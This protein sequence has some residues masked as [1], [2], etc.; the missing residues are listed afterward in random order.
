MDKINIRNLE[1][2]AN[3]GVFPEENV[4]GQKFVISATL[5]VSTYKAGHSDEITDSVH[6][7]EVSHFMK[8]FAEGRT[9]KLVESLAERM[10]EAVLDKFSLIQQIDLEIKKP[11]APIGLPLEDVSIEISRGW[12]TAYIA[13]GSN[14]GDR[15]A[16]IDGAVKSLD[17]LEGCSVEKTAEYIE[18]EPYGGVEQDDFLNTVLELRTLLPPEVLLERLHDIENAAGRERTVRWGPRTLDLDIVLYDNLVLDS[19]DL[20][21][22]HMEMHKRDFVLKPLMEIAPYLRHPITKK[23]IKELWEKLDK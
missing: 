10:A 9:Y 7:G 13:L 11:W 6:Y 2:F 22:P 23:S 3:H 18:T 21:I 5:Y 4:L 8:A 16:Y 19:P 15:K 1:V 20:V 12:H 17:E 14:M